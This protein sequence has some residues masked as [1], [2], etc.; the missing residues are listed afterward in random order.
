MYDKQTED[1]ALEALYRDCMEWQDRT[2]PKQSARTTGPGALFLLAA[3]MIALAV[4]V[5]LT[6]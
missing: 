6:A 4:L 5:L 1:R 3:G 2:A